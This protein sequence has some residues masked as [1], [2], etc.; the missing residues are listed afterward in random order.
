MTEQTKAGWKITATTV[1]C[2]S[3]I[4]F[5][6]IMVRP[7]GTAACSWVSRRSWTRDGSGGR[8]GGGP[9]RWPDC[10]LVA[11]FVKTSLNI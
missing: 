8:G 10:P 3:V 1:R 7:D 2:P 9:C 6:T 4:D 11:D 5:A